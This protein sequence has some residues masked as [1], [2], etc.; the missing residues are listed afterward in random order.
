[1]KYIFSRRRRVCFLLIGGIAVASAFLG[2]NVLTVRSK[3]AAQ[4][5]ARPQTQPPIDYRETVGTPWTGSA[6]IRRTTAQLAAFDASHPVE[7][8]G[9][10]TTQRLLPPDRSTLTEDPG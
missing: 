7:R 10:L 6:P 2:L 8:S 4:K 5:Q 3:A 9:K 1:M